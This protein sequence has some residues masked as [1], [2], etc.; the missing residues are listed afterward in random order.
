MDP[1]TLGTSAYGAL[2]VFS[3]CT[4]GAQDAGKSVGFAKRRYRLAGTYNLAWLDRDFSPSA[5]TDGFDAEQIADIGRFLTSTTVTPWLSLLAVACLTESPDH[6]LIDQVKAGLTNEARKWTAEKPNSWLKHAE[7]V[8]DR[9][10]EIHNEVLPTI[11]AESDW[12][13]DVEYF[14]NFVNTPLQKKTSAPGSY[15]SRFIQHL[16]RLASDIERLR[17]AFDISVSIAQSMATTALDPIITHTELGTGASADFD[18]LYVERS[19]VDFEGGRPLDSSVIT[20][21]NTPFRLVVTGAPGAGK[22]TYLQ[23]FRRQLC[24]DQDRPVFVVRCREYAAINWDRTNLIDFM[25]NRYN[26]E[27]S[28]ELEPSTIR[29]LLVL[30][31]AVVVLD[32]LD[33]VTDP[34]RRIDLVKR[35]NALSSAFPIVSILVTSREVGYDRAPLDRHIFARVQLKEFELSQ[36]LE[37]VGRWFSVVGKKELIEPFIHDSETVADLRLNP[38]MLSLLCMLYRE[39]HAIPSMRLDIYS[40]CARLLFKR[41]DSHRQIKVD[42]AIPDFSD[43]LMQEIARWYYT[44]PTAQAGLDET[45]IK[46]MLKR[47][48]IDQ[49]GFPESRAEEAA[50]EFLEFCAGRA[51]LL[52]ATG[53][54]KRGERLFSFTHK[55]FSEYFAA[56]S[57]ARNAVDAVEICDRITSTFYN[58]SSSLLP[59]LLI[60]SYG[61]HSAQGAMRIVKELHARNAPTLLLLRLVEGA[62]LPAQSRRLVFLQLLDSWIAGEPDKREF[63]ALLQLNALAREQFVSE[64]LLGSAQLRQIFLSG[65]ATVVL[66]GLS[67]RYSP[68]WS[69]TVERIT[70]DTDMKGLARRDTAVWNW[71]A[72]QLDTKI[73]PADKL[74]LLLCHGVFGFAPGI[75]W[76]GVESR[77]RFNKAPVNESTVAKYI[78]GSLSNFSNGLRLPSGFL[79]GLFYLLAPGRTELAWSA[80]WAPDLLSTKEF[81]LFAYL[82][83]ALYEWLGGQSMGDKISSLWSGTLK[84]V[85]EV[86][87]E[88]VVGGSPDKECLAAATQTLRNLPDRLAMWAIGRDNLVRPDSSH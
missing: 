81:H 12:A 9:L 23:H 64:H 7:L 75:A 71:H 18:L 85:V 76:Y 55:T 67:D 8:W 43:S 44:S 15:A 29:D 60:Q 84:E 19:F 30:G 68:S 26:S 38:L 46:G 73:Q 50:A 57:F 40:E 62:L 16:V 2:R 4:R 61:K 36:A 59:E 27:Y 74:D 28:D 14:E 39:S 21:G 31:R 69:S 70:A 10:L 5:D 56:E 34:L 66:S 1:V 52:G 54:N 48:L 77:L 82:A 88:S 13:A 72:T 78:D 33:E 45:V 58:D 86:R 83:L 22:T 65:W 6:T 32:G 53:S 49:S 47:I 41:W 51:W 20:S 25:L 37:Y 35:I 24:T 17:A 63:I 80:R 11:E 79:T 3:A 42:G 87:S